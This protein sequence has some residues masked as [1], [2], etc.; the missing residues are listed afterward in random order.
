MRIF[1]QAVVYTVLSFNAF[2]EPSLV[3]TWKGSSSRCT[4]G[5]TP[6]FFGISSSETI[7][8]TDSDLSY[9]TTVIINNQPCTIK[10]TGTYTFKNEILST[11]G[12]VISAEGLACRGSAELGSPSHIARNIPAKIVGNEL[13]LPQAGP[14]A[15][16]PEGD[17][18]IGILVKQ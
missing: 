15:S 5:A 14:S 11:I 8:F 9:E 17:I 16:C 7:T 2:G 3:G 18:F 6:Q 10:G 12:K 13:Y 4:S 1:F